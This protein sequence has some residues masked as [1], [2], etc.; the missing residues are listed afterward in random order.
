M[1]TT[2]AGELIEHARWL[3]RNGGGCLFVEADLF[4]HLCLEIELQLGEMGVVG[5]V[6]V[7]EFVTVRGV[8]IEPLVELEKA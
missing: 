1:T 6:S 7:P 2:F 8:R 5:G 3:A 4:W